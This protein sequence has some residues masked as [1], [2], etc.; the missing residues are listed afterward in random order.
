MR[1]ATHTQTH[2]HT[3]THAH[4][5]SRSHAQ[6]H[7]R[8]HAHANEGEAR[9]VER[10]RERVCVYGGGGGR[11]IWGERMRR[12]NTTNSQT[13]LERHLSAAQA[14]LSCEFQ[15]V[16]VLVHDTHTPV[17]AQNSQ[18]PLELSAARALLWIRALLWK[19]PL[20]RRA[21]AVI[22]RCYGSSAAMG[23]LRFVGSLKL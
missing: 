13:P 16:C 23:W 2:T 14:P 20:E 3:H 5:Y 18:A 7:T 10:E 4:M 15:N 22:E 21:S 12:C 6:T 17:H 11:G 1:G 19:A 8:T 9:D